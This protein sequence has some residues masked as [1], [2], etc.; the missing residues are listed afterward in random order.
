MLVKSLLVPVSAIF[1]NRF[2][3][4]KLALYIRPNRLPAD[5]PARHPSFE[6]SISL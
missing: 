4:L 5:F 3:G 6:R 2:K 1:M